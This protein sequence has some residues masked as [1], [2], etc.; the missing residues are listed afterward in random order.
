[1]AKLTTKL[2]DLAG[3]AGRWLGLGQPAPRHTGAVEAD[4]FDEMT[5]REI[6]SQ[7]AA[8]RELTENLGERHDYAADL[9]RDV[10]LAAYK[11]SPVVRP[12]AEMDRSRLVNRAVVEGLLRS[13]EF[14]ELRRDT[15][16]D[17][18]ASAMAVLAMEG[19][20]R[21]ALEQAGQAQQAAD[22]AARAQEEERE[23]AAAVQQAIEAATA[24][25]DENAQVPD[26]AAGDVQA[27]IAAAQQAAERATAAGQAADQ[28]LA[29]AAP[30]M[31][32]GLRAGAQKAGD[33]SREEA[34]LMAAWGTS[35]GELQRM[36]L[37]TRRKL[38]ERLRTGRMAQFTGLIGRFRQM[39]AGQRA[40]RMENVP[41]ELVG[42]Q[43]GDDLG[44]LIPSWRP[45]GCP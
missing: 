10:F 40:R 44:R 7:A 18:Y 3:K 45:S 2:A 21:R 26:G 37:Q 1:M 15:A 25:A 41:G 16:G 17:V 34:A 31:H 20:L 27:A 43:T 28:T 29:G 32:A 39:A 9:V 19:N 12:E 14:A 6:T 5:W 42:I 13:P 24:A 36:D 33:E 35:P 23:A 38:A 4:R 30:G 11:A 22:E 8:L